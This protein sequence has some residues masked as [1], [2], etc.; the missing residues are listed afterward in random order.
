[1][2]Y[3]HYFL[4]PTC[5]AEAQ[6]INI[7]RQRFRG[8]H[9]SY[10]T[11][12]GAETKSQKLTSFTHSLAPHEGRVG[13]AALAL[14]RKEGHDKRTG[15]RR[16]EGPRRVFH[17]ELPGRK[18]RMGLKWED[19][20]INGEWFCKGEMSYKR[21]GRELRMEE[22]ARRGRNGIEWRKELGVEERDRG[23]QKEGLVKR[24]KWQ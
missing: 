22:G 8:Y 20:V 7:L 17:G 19:D 18:G 24:K 15:A 3:S 14:Y 11:V 2:Q 1:M 21:S 4:V 6:L 23:G 12:C 13:R 9:Q 16:G 10:S 5:K